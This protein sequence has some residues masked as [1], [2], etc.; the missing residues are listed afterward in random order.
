MR[1]RLLAG[2]LCWVSGAP[3]RPRLLRL[4]AALAAVEAGGSGTG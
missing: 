1:L 2:A 3:Y 4:E